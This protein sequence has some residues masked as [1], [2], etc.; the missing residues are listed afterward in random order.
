MQKSN[1]IDAITKLILFIMK[2]P[3]VSG[4]KEIISRR[5]FFKKTAKNILPVLGLI[6]LGSSPLSA[7][8][9]ELSPNEKMD[10]SRSC[11]TGCANHCAGT[12]SSRCDITCTSGCSSGCGR[13]CKSSCAEGCNGQTSNSTG[14]NGCTNHCWSSC[15]GMCRNSC[16]GSCRASSYKGR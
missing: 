1:E 12:C 15:S 11:T 16:D 4:I 14:C 7:L 13:G 9:T 5:D 3:L 2:V 10:C 8:A 6:T